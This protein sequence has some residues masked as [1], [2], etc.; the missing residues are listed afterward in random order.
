M[1]KLLFFILIAGMAA[2]KKETPDGGLRFLF[3]PQHQYNYRSMEAFVSTSLYSES[4]LSAG[5][6]NKDQPIDLLP[7]K[8]GNYYWHYNITFDS[9]NVIL[10]SQSFTG[11]V[12][13]EKGKLHEIIIED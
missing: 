13:V 7:L 5:A 12:L 2:C 11:Q 8:E 1:R 4:V 10:G 6:A 3:H 9:S